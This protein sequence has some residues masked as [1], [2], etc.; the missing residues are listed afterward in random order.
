M[1]FQDYRDAVDVIADQLENDLSNPHNS[2]EW[3]QEMEGKLFPAFTILRGGRLM[4]AQGLIKF[5]YLEVKVSSNPQLDTTELFV[6]INPL[7]RDRAPM[8]GSL[9]EF[10][11]APRR[12]HRLVLWLI[13]WSQEPEFTFT[14]FLFREDGPQNMAVKSCHLI[15]KEG[16]TVSTWYY[17]FPYEAPQELEHALSSA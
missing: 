12:N 4:R 14:A 9:C 3:L 13:D 1:E 2:E 17:D 7:Y 8:Q 6:E 11:M 10:W 16:A 5:R 15:N